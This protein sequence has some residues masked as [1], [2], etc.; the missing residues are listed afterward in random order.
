MFIA[1]AG[2][3]GSGKSTL[4]DMLSRYYQWEPF[5]ESVDNNPYIEDFYGDMRRWSF[6][7]QVYFLS[8]RFITH[9]KIAGLSHNVVQD[10]SIYEDAEIFAANLH[11]IGNMDD[12]DYANYSELY[13]IM[14]PFLKAPDLL[15]YLRASVPTLMRQIRLRGRAYEQSIQESYIVQLNTLYESW[16]ARYQFGPVL[17]IETDNLDFVH[18]EQ[19]RAGL[20]GT[21][22]ETVSSL[23]TPQLP[24]IT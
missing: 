19:D 14:I 6:H 2:N 13:G 18:S 3:I 24:F 10:R 20:L 17:T 23:H 9:Q 21:I 4:T 1:I 7:L 16:I 22:V 5:Y 8:Q 15:V 12:R 11:D